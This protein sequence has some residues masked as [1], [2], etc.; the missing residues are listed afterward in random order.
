MDDDI[1]AVSS[2]GGRE[3]E[4]SGV[5][6]HKDINPMGP[7]SHLLGPHVTLITPIEAPSLT[8]ATLGH[9]HMNYRRIQLFSP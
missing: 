9:Q 5:S 6:S 7:G 3:S 4:L 1:L 8:T 2:Q